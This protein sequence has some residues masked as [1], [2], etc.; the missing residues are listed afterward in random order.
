MSD[1]HVKCICISELDPYPEYNDSDIEWIGKIPKE[2]DTVRI[3]W[4]SP[5]KRGASPRPI[6]DPIYF[7]DNGDFSWVRIADVTSSERYLE[8]TTQKL[9]DLGSSL[10]VKQYPGDFFVSIAGSVGKPIITKIKCCIHDGFVWFPKLKLNSEYLYYIFTSGEPYKGLGK[11]GTQLNLNTETVGNISI[12]LPPEEYEINEIV[13]FLDRETSLIDMLVEKKQHFIEL[14]EEKRAALISHTVTKGLDHDVPTKYSGI[15]WIGEIPERWE[16]NKLKHSASINPNVLPENTDPEFVLK[17]VD[18]GNVGLG[19]M[20]DSPKEMKF[21][22]APSRARKVVRENDIIISTV[23]TYLKAILHLIN[24]EP[25]LIVSTGFAV[26]R[27][28]SFVNHRYLFYLIRSNQF[29]DS[30]MSHSEGVSYPA[31]N[32]SS[33]GDLPICYPPLPEQQAIASYLDRETAQ[34]DTL[35]E[36]IKQS[37]E[38]LKEYRT[39]LISDAVTGKIDVRGTV[40]E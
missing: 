13:S 21:I 31:I 37:I 20:V 11:L 38:Y 39:A 9:S 26:L 22:D 7:D 16:V 27:P 5:V 6:D 15:E 30:V 10:S 24:P 36:K 1:S 35:L 19:K 23:R 12:P 40:C 3:K 29:I 18:I 33:L 8:K 4:F 25:N 34:I 17:Y 32:S 2:W 28:R 14:L